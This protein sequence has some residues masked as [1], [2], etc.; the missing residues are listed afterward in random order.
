MKIQLILVVA[1]LLIGTASA[2]QASKKAYSKHNIS[3]QIPANWNV[4]KDAQSGNDTQIV[5]SD[6]TNA[7][8]V[9]LI[10]HS[11]IGKII[12]DYL[13]NHSSKSELDSMPYNAA[14]W[15]HAYEQYPWYSNDAICKYYKENV[16]N[17]NVTSGVGSGISVKPDDVEYAGVSTN[18][19][20]ITDS[21]AK[22]NE[23]VVAWTKPQY[24]DEIIGVHS[25][26]MGKF[27]NVSVE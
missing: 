18:S 20:S 22:V 26:F 7:I 5:L 27:S 19:G 12:G 25:L 15:R 2:D 1:V 10:K 23:W 16:I 13:T 24:T 4:T 3:F 14:T 21:H 17:T 6:G 8:R 11:D 9:D